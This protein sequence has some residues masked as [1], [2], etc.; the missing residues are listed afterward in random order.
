MIGGS[1]GDH[2]EV[3]GALAAAEGTIRGAS[4]RERL[5]LAAPGL[6]GRAGGAAR[7]GG[8]PDRLADRRAGAALRPGRLRHARPVAGA[9]HSAARVLPAWE[10]DNPLTSFVNG[11]YAFGLEE[12]NE[13][14][15]AEDVARAA[16][17]GNPSDAWATHAL[18]HVMETANRQEE[19]I[20]FLKGT[21][22]FWSQAHFMAGH[23]GWHLA[24]Y[25]IEQGRVD[26]ALADYDRFVAP[27]LD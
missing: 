8:H 15:R 3:V 12:T 4:D 21:R 19:G 9:P 24:L 2:P 16:L 23:N 7:L 25:L 1:A 22:G 27:K 14:S 5:H 6:G 26:E 10:R 17:A 13:L 18:A 11:A 20:A